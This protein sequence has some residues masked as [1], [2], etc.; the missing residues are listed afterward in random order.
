MTN[1]FDILIVGGGQA[2]RRAAQ[3]AR[4][5]RPEASIAIL[6][7]ETHRP[8]DRP[9]LSKSALKE[10]G[11]EHENQE[12]VLEG[13]TLLLGERADR[14]DREARTVHTAKGAVYGYERLIIATGSRVR[15]LDLPEELA[16]DVF[17]LRTRDDADRLRARLHGGPRV[18][19]IGAGFIGLEV[20]AA[21]RERG[22]EVVVIDQADRVLAR[23]FPSAG[24]ARVQSLHEAAGVRFLLDSR[25]TA[26]ARNDR[27][28][29]E[30]TT[31]KGSVEA[32]LIVVGIGVIPNTELAQE[33]GLPVDN[34][35]LV[36]EFGRTADPFIYGAGEVTRHPVSGSDIACRLESWHVAEYQAEAAGASAAGKPQ[37]YRAL[38]WFWSDQF[39][40]NIQMLGHVPITADLVQ[41][42][43]AEG[44]CTLFAL[45]ADHRIIGALAFNNGRDISAV[46]RVMAK[47]SSIDPARLADA[48]T[49]WRDLLG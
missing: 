14:L 20:G 45:D 35:L 10:S 29:I 26:I 3:A 11:C 40:M 12:H 42:G 23:V 13:I 41:R 28:C 1:Q 31:S 33:A 46:R 43:T 48:Q 44:P 47:G 7:E 9:P 15:R 17:Y 37:A 16:P 32:D 25:I 21:A 36:D 30:I 19:V 8:Y 34:G 5:A 24:S 6:G 27:S 22:S 39:D 18:A 4:A 38:P 2:G 49:S